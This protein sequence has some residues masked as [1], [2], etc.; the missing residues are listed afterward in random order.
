MGRSIKKIVCCDTIHHL[1]PIL[2]GWYFG[3]NDLGYDCTYLPIPQY[4]PLDLEE[5]PDLL[6]YAGVKLEH[7]D[8][9]KSFREKCPNCIVVGITPNYNQYYEK[10]HECEKHN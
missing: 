3:F 2:K 6:I 9:L 1:T 7:L 5:T 10:M 4:S 8:M